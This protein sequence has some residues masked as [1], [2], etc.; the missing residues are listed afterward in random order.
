[1]DDFK[2]AACFQT[3]EKFI[4]ALPEACREALDDDGP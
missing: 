2:C 4:G 1:M 3:H